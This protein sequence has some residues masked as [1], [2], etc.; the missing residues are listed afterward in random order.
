MMI[1]KCVSINGTSVNF[2]FKFC[3]EFSFST[4]Y[5]TKMRLEDAYDTVR[6]YMSIFLKHLF[7]LMIHLD[8]ANL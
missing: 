8:N 7:L 1:H 3:E 5:G 4:D 6:T 2:S